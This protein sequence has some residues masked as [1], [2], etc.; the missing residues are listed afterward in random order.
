MN[1]HD[2]NDTKGRDVRLRAQAWN[3]TRARML[4]TLEECEFGAITLYM[5]KY[6]I[7]RALEAGRRIQHG[8]K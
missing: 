4:A 5:S 1:Y 3:A 8:S 2:H 7:R 6:D